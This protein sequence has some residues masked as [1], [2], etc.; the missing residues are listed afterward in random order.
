MLAVHL[1]AAVETVPYGTVVRVVV[2]DIVVRAVAYGTEGMT[3]HAQH[4]LPE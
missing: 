3:V 4:A 1:Y 2:F